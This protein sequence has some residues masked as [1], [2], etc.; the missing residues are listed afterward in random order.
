MA[1]RTA[2][3]T[4]TPVMQYARDLRDRYPEVSI[5]DATTI[6]RDLREL[7]L[8]STDDPHAARLQRQA[9]AAYLRSFEDE[10]LYDATFGKVSRAAVPV[11]L[12]G[13]VGLYMTWAFATAT[14]LLH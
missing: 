10:S 7:P 3:G 9:R 12:A 5:R 2:T 14:A 8:P 11:V 4:L 6:L 1:R 13:I